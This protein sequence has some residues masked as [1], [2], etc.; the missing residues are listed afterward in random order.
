MTRIEFVSRAFVLTLSSLCLQLASAAP[1]EADQVGKQVITR[2]GALKLEKE[3]S[4][5]DVV[6]GVI[7]A[8]TA[9]D[10]GT[11]TVGIGFSGI[12]PF[13]GGGFKPLET[14]GFT[15]TFGTY[16]PTA[17]TGGTSVA[18]IWDSGGDI[19]CR[20]VVG[21]SFSASGFSANPGSSWLS[22]ITCNQ[23]TRTGVSASSFQYSNGTATWFWSRLGFGFPFVRS[24]SCSIAHN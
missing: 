15:S 1:P 4:A 2:D 21:S 14:F 22:S 6:V 8:A 23:V 18:D 24:T 7:P 3:L 13:T 12:C 5:D 19:L 17:L 16:S 10:L 20:P 9:T 11:L